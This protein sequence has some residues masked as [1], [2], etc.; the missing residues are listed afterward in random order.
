MVSN[1]T[2]TDYEAALERVEL[3]ELSRSKPSTTPDSSYEA[4][5]LE[6]MTKADYERDL[7]TLDAYLL[8][9]RAS[10]SLITFMKRFRPS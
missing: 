10:V 1:P 6:S 7:G 4:E 5:L 2:R 3:F 8:Y 9:A